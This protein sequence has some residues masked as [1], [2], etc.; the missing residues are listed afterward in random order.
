M[1]RS[2]KVSNFDTFYDERND[3][4]IMVVT[5]DYHSKCAYCKVKEYFEDS[6]RTGS[7]ITTQNFTFEE[8]NRMKK[9]VFDNE[10]RT[11]IQT[12]L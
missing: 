10:F 8:L 1:A 4:Y 7:L 6:E 12:I 3:R 11:H 2:Y 5:A 9:G